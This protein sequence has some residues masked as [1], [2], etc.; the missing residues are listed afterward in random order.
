MTWLIEQADEDPN[1]FLRYLTKKGRRRIINDPING[2]PY[3]YRYHLFKNKNEDDEQ[4][5]FNIFLHKIVQSDGR[6][7][8]DHPWNYATL[9]LK[10]GYWENTPTGKFWRGP[11]SIRFNRAKNLHFIRLGSNNVEGR[12]EEIPCTTLFIRFKKKQDWGFLVN[13][14]WIDSKIYFAGKYYLIEG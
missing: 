12:V 11:G 10:G 3:M 6:H 8:H 5:G 4:T 2:R 14:S 9:I 1:W 7:L 13:G